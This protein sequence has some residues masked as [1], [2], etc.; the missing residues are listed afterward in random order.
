MKR[1]R[2]HSFLDRLLVGPTPHEV[3]R[4]IIEVGEEARIR[5]SDLRQRFSYD[6][7]LSLGD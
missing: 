7:S 1:N 2:R 5:H 3:L 4:L 6:E